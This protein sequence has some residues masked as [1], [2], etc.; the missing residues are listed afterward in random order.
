MNLREN[1]QLS[2]TVDGSYIVLVTMLMRNIVQHIKDYDQ[3]IATYEWLLQ[4]L[5]EVGKLNKENM[6]LIAQ[7]AWISQTAA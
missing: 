7:M 3:P 1:Q 6:Q 2:E 4:K 5:A